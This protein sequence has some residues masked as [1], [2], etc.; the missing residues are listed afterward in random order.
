MEIMVHPLCLVLGTCALWLTIFFSPT[1]KAENSIKGTKTLTYTK[2]AAR[3]D[4]PTRRNLVIT[5]QGKRKRC[6]RDFNSVEQQQH[7]REPRVSPL[8]TVQPPVPQ[9]RKTNTGTA[10]RRSGFNLA[11]NLVKEIQENWRGFESAL[12]GP[13]FQRVQHQKKGLCW[14]GD[15]RNRAS[16]STMNRGFVGVPGMVSTPMMLGEII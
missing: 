12:P 4:L 5:L 16:T 10:S 13:H 9:E 2:L 3:Q 14:R 1:T 11:K 7:P 15:R 6:P 8:T